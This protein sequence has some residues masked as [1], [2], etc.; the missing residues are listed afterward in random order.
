MEQMMKPQ[1]LH[2]QMLATAMP[3]TP[4]EVE[5]LKQYSTQT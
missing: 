4:L 3:P 1:K 5:V 2:L